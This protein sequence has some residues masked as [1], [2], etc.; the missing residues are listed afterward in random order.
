[1]NA[2]DS[3][4]TKEFPFGLTHVSNIRSKNHSFGA[5]VVAQ[6]VEWPLPTPEVL[7]SNPVIGKYIEQLFT[8]NCVFIEKTNIRS[9]NY[10][11]QPVQ[12]NVNPK[13]CPSRILNGSYI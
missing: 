6:L 11:L 8:V 12:L 13:V 10:N 2:Q 7:G 9:I 4:K 1:M 5:V 3:E